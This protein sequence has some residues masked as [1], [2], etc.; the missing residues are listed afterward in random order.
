MKFCFEASV[1]FCNK[2]YETQNIDESKKRIF[3]KW[4]PKE[5]LERGNF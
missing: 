5:K 1:D 3:Q 2:K 4:I